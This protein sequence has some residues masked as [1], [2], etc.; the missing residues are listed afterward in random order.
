M[1]GT[2]EHDRF[3]SSQPA[4]PPASGKAGVGAGVGIGV[5]VGQSSQRRAS[6]SSRHNRTFSAAAAEGERMKWLRVVLSSNR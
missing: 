2:G 1:N 6:L 3:D 4:Q 5:G